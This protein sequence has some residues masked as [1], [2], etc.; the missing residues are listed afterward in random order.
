MQTFHLIQVSCYNISIE[1]AKNG[2]KVSAGKKSLSQSMRFTGKCQNTSRLLL[3]LVISTFDW[4]A[5]HTNS[6]GMAWLSDPLPKLFTA[7]SYFTALQ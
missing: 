4:Q 3:S 5:K 7:C 6:Y 2:P 1:R